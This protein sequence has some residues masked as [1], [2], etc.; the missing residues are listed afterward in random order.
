MMYKKQ[1][2]EGMIIQINKLIR[3]YFYLLGNLKLAIFLL[4]VI[5][6]SSSLGTI[7]EQEKPI[8]FYEINYP[9]D[10]PM[11]GLIN[12]ESIKLFG[13]N[14]IY[15]TKWFLLL[16]ILFGSSLISCT[17]SRQIPSFKLA[18]LWQFF[19]REKIQNKTG[20]S[21]NLKK[22]SLMQFSYLLRKKNYN[23]VQEGPYLYAYKGLIGKIG[24][25]LVHASI[26]IILLGAIIGSLTG[27]MSQ[28]V[29]PK[30]E[31]FHV[32]NIIKSGPL[33]Y[34][35]Q[36]FETY[37]ND[38]KITYTDQGL[39]DQFYSD[40]YILDTNLNVRSK[41]TIFV[42]EPLRFE[43]I[44]YYQTDWSISMLIA[45]INDHDEIQI[46]LQEIT[47]QNN[48]RFWIGSLDRK[49]NIIVV[50]E[51]LSGKYTV[52]DS[53]KKFLAESEIGKKIFL[54]G[55]KIRITK[56]IPSTGLQ[57]KSDIGIPV[58]YCGFLI[59]I[60][61]VFFSYSSYFQ[62]WAV[63]IHDNVYIFGETNRAIYFFQKNIIEFIET[64]QH[65]IIKFK[66]KN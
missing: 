60:C 15:K 30:G 44:T 10:N 40:I 1:Y 47:I 31:L 26:I 28:E 8:I 42:N 63:K 20:L 16:L 13:L 12:S 52:Y 57:I 54:N 48:I 33:S 11:F 59:L 7:I 35:R 17:L 21:F 55:N 32:Q 25:I 49:N 65:E 45:S 58:V 56:V 41:K 18:R 22:T 23:V 27:F 43:D 4:L 5:A 66:I 62:I 39:I 51:D 50:L 9:T 36:D 38:F 53:E 61:S 37:V 6:I 46:P 3:K 24:P 29:I 34:I 19:K 14:E 2:L 64:L